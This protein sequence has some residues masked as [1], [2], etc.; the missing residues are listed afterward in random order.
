MAGRPKRRAAEARR[1]GKKRRFRLRGAALDHPASRKGKTW[2]D[3]PDPKPSSSSHKPRSRMDIDAPRRQQG[4]KKKWV[5]RLDRHQK[6]SLRWAEEADSGNQRGQQG[7]LA[8]ESLL[9]RFAR[10]IPCPE[11]G[12]GVG[13]S[14]TTGFVHYARQYHL[15]ESVREAGGWGPFLF[16]DAPVPVG[17]FAAEPPSYFFPSLVDVPCPTCGARGMEP[18]VTPSGKR[19]FGGGP[20]SKH[21]ARLMERQE[22]PAQRNPKEAHRNLDPGVRRRK[23][24]FVWFAL[25]FP[26]C[27][28]EQNWTMQ[29]FRPYSS[30]KKAERSARRAVQSRFPGLH[31]FYGLGGAGTPVTDPHSPRA[32]LGRGLGAAKSIPFVY[33]GPARLVKAGVWQPGKSLHLEGI[34]FTSK[35]E[36]DRYE[37]YAEA[38]TP[39][40]M[41]FLQQLGLPV[42]PP[43]LFEL[44]IGNLYAWTLPKEF[45]IEDDYGLLPESLRQP[46]RRYVFPRLKKVLPRSEWPYP[47]GLGDEPGR[48]AFV[49]IWLP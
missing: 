20:D 33:G 32:H 42:V 46:Y 21:K 4:E 24:E 37:R 28:G 27:C 41:A 15:R 3:D 34:G 7:R 31:F 44:Q 8:H 14:C 2:A 40:H 29:S 16:P 48:K 12:A 43:A 30:R 36:A 13:E 1:N 45:W 5:R 49:E 10:S 25:G 38:I 22:P 26:L 9:E 6:E 23:Q 35:R 39:I 47:I 17:G 19:F 11:C 18:C